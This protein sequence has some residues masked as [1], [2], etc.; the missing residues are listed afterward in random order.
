MRSPSTAE[1]QAARHTQ[2]VLQDTLAGARSVDALAER[3]ALH[4]ESLVPRGRAR[5][6]EIG[7]NATA[8]HAALSAAVQDRASRVDWRS[9]DLLS[10]AQE[11]RKHDDRA[12]PFE[13]REFDIALI[14][15][16]L[17]RTE[18]RAQVLEAAG[19]LARRVL[20]KDHFEYGSY[21][22]S[23]L[24]RYFTREAFTRLATEQQF[25]ITALDCGLSLYEHVPVARTL[26]PP[27][28]DFIAVLRRAG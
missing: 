8:G 21:S 26:M 4:I 23:M 2:A 5:C 15:D 19:R 24:Q 3:I 13:E 25:V 27:D 11:A 10:L 12:V 22:R 1:E 16:V 7:G 14:C 20:V 9:M 17:R 6:L 28:C 18:N